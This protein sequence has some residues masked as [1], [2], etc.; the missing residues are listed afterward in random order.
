MS[1]Q[2]KKRLKNDHE[3]LVAALE[4]NDFV[5]L[6][7][8]KGDPPNQYTIVYKF[9]GATF[10]PSTGE[11]SYTTHHEIEITLFREYPTD[12]PYCK[13]QTGIFHPNISASE[14]WIADEGSWSPS[15][16]VLDVVK[17]VGRMISYQDYDLGSPLNEE[18]AKWAK[19]N[20]S[21]FPLD[22]TDFFARDVAE[23]EGE[24]RPEAL[25]TYCLEPNPSGVCSNDHPT[26]DDCLAPCKHCDNT[27]CLACA[28]GL[29]SEGREKVEAYRS[30]IDAAMNQG[31]IGQAEKVLKNALRDLPDVP[32][33]TK[34]LEKVEKI[35]EHMG[36]IKEFAKSRCFHGIVA[37]CKKLEELGFENQ[38]LANIESK[39]SEK[40]SEADVVVARGREEIEAKGNPEGACKYFSKALQMVQ[41][42]PDALTL[43]KQTKSN[44]DKAKQD[45]ES[46]QRKFAQGQYGPAIIDAKHALSMDPRWASKAEELIETASH[47][48]SAKQRKKKKLIAA[49]L[50]AGVALILVTAAGFYVFEQRRLNSEYQSFLQE[51]ENVPFDEGKV[52]L[53]KVYVL[54]NKANK[55]TKD[56]QNRINGINANIEEHNL[57]TAKR[58]AGMM[59]EKKDYEKAEAIYQEFLSQ[60]PDTI[61]ANELNRNISEIRDL[62]DENDYG[63]AVSL[64][65]SDPKTRVSTYRSYLD[66]HP[67]GK[68]REE[69]NELMQQTSGAY[70]EQ[71]KQEIT[72]LKANGNWLN[73]VETCDE[74]DKNLAKSQWADEVKI[75]RAECQKNRTEDELLAG[76][77]A[78]V[79]AKGTDDEAVKQVYLSYLKDHPDSSLETEIRKR[80]AALDEKIRAEKDWDETI[81]YVVSEKNKL[82]QRISRLKK[83]VAQN[84]SGEHSKEAT[85]KIKELEERRDD[86]MWE[87][88]VLAY[89]NSKIPPE[90]KVALLEAFMEKNA[91]GKHLSDAEEK[92]KGLEGEL[93]KAAWKRVASYADN[94]SISM[95]DRIKKLTSYVN[96]NPSGKYSQYAQTRLRKLRRFQVEEGKIRRL[97]AQTGNAFTYRNGIITDKRTH[98]MWCAFDSYLDLQKCFKHESTAQYVRRL[99]YG[100]YTDWRLPSEAEVQLVY[101][102]KPFLPTATDGEWYWTSGPRS[103]RMVPVVFTDKRGGSSSAKIEADVGCGSVRAVRGP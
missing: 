1:D 97:A 65:K 103:G 75:L 71:F 93:G 87:G 92:L 11:T 84:P 102:N 73:C 51:V 90:R 36:H 78:E 34:N 46:A 31:N 76:L 49:I 13:S 88:V 22:S 77:I 70:Y 68:H 95:P 83:Y 7:E 44:M 35:K 98:L 60:H 5:E 91:T 3:R 59:L 54:S 69:V 40:L 45:M 89:D 28:D 86:V 17:Q 53:L 25:C 42:H 47:H 8:T 101:K 74:F 79:E 82:D 99:N 14:L 23:P 57:E 6:L 80:V 43:L 12:P 26:C 62:M 9:K 37:E 52:E 39:A 63:A 94:Q 56:A 55:H 100:G 21:A 81:A 24:A 27:V 85:D 10:D 64:S 19:E 33:L 67:E 38:T 29:C 16:T 66:K 50:A 15:K 2:R 41:D 18:A 48:L 58:D 61:H 72:H 4:G 32:I 96:Q 30:E 20:E